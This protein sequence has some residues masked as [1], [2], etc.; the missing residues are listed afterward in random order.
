[1]DLDL[2]RLNKW[3]DSFSNFERHPNKNLLNLS[4]M[5]KLCSYFNHP[6]KSYKCF[7]VAGS[8]GKGTISINIASIL[9]SAGYKVG[10]YTSPH[11]L[12]FTERVSSATGPF[13]KGI[14]DSAEKE[15]K[16]GIKTIIEKSI[17]PA[18]LL[19]WFELVTIFAMLCFRKAKVDYAVFEV[20]MGG[21]L[22]AT[23][24]ISPLCIA[25]GPIELEH[26]EYLGDTLSKIAAE[27]AGIFKPNVPIISAP[28][29]KEVSQVLDHTAK[30]NSVFISY[31]PDDD[32]QLVDANIARLA[33]KTILPDI[34][35]KLIDSGLAK[36]HLPARYE[37][38]KNPPSTYLLID[39]AHTINS[40]KAVLERM[41]KDH[42]HGNLL[43]GCAADKNVEGIA[44][45]IL[46]SHLFDK[47]FL[48][49]P[50]DF[51]KSNL[52]RIIKAFYPDKNNVEA[53]PDFKYLI[54]KALDD[55]S[56]KNLPLVVLGSFYL[57]G[58]VKA[59]IQ[60]AQQK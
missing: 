23:N 3:L 45:I 58:E 34:P 56:A 7:H 10:V 8:K 44:E 12:H 57:A 59:I 52:E 11:V 5:Q 43:F 14:Y 46:D 21:R 19:T 24:V 54:K 37:I 48:T 6:E 49:K 33:I 4:T 28:Q 9:D 55:S 60:T 2:I 35:D 39:G 50:G 47:I 36:A 25:I 20:G 31:V 13:S 27:K 32:Y 17:L 18:K 38:I 26:T 16:A 53:N 40:V 30:D 42:I 51:K 41:K 29:D 15:L 1:M 22:D